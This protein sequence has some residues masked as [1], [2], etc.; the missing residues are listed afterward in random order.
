M[1]TITIPPELEAPLAEE[2]RRQGTSLELLAVESLRRMYGP[3][4]S[5]KCSTKCSTMAPTD[6]GTLAD[7]LQ[8]YI[9]TIQGT[10]EPLSEDT[11]RRYREMLHEREQNSS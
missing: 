2:A 1:S 11:G 10:S 6:G 9:G 5:T 4:S 3:K 8:G 7:F